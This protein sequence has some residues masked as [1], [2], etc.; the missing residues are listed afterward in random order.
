MNFVFLL[1]FVGLICAA[2]H[3]DLPELLQACFHHAKQFLR[4]DVVCIM[5]I[6][7]ENYYW[8]YTSASELVNMILAFTETKAHALFHLPDFLNLSESMVQMIMCRN[9]EIPEVRK[10]EAMLAWAKNKV[11][12]KVSAKTDVKVEFRCIM[13]RLTRDLKLHRISPQELI[14]VV[15]PSKAIKNERILETLMYQA[16]SGMY[17]IQDSY[18]EACQQRIQKQDSRYSEW[19]ES[20]DCGL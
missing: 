6:S 12:Q 3:Y 17:R 16:N 8:R 9:L 15:L 18:I 7:L 5:L 4:I 19:G 11:K 20:F 13:E 1:I 10:F 14:K 2:E